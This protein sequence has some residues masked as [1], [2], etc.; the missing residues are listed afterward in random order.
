MSFDS[1]ASARLEAISRASTQSIRYFDRPRRPDGKPMTTSEY[2]GCNTFGWDLMSQKLPAGDVVLLREETPSK[3]KLSKDLADKVA[4]AVKEWALEKGAT[5]YCHWF[6]PQTGATAEKHDAFFSFGKDGSAMER[7]TGKELMQQEP[8][9]SSFPSGGLRSTF[10]AR[11]YTAWDATSPM[12]LMET[13]NGLTLCIPSIF[14]SYSGHS[15]D[16]KTPLLR[17]L[18]AISESTKES[19]SLLAMMTPNMLLLTVGQSR[20][21]LS[22]IVR[23]IPSP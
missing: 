6:H 7:F 17:S 14:I 2:F 13:T 23:F 1:R 3:R 11:G 12:F 20:N 18:S 4:F 15:L 10:E 21:I 16:E 5:H 19:L 22:S 9:A 8:D